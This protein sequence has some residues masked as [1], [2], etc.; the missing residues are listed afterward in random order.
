MEEL[1]IITNGNLTEFEA[2]EKLLNLTKIKYGNSFYPYKIGIHA[3]VVTLTEESYSFGCVFSTSASIKEGL[4]KGIGECLL[5]L[6][7]H[8]EKNEV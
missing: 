8:I 4:A 6:K 2:V 7:E 5:K 3:G 1:K